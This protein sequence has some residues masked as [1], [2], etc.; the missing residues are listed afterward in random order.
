MASQ[1]VSDNIQ[2]N[3]QDVILLVDDNPDNLQVLYQTLSSLKFKILIAK[4]GQDAIEIAQQTHPALI[5]LDIMM[6]GVN[7]FEVIKQLKAN[8]V[9]ENSAVIF[10][11]A[12]DD[13]KHK[14]E[15]FKLGAV[16]YISKPFQG[17]EVLA[18]VRTHMKII[19]LERELSQKNEQLETD[20]SNIMQMMR[21]GLICLNQH[22]QICYANPAAIEL[23]GWEE[24]RLIKSNFHETIQFQ[25][26][27]KQRIPVQ[28]SHIIRALR[29]G[30]SYSSDREF[31]CHASGNIFAVEYSI[32]PLT[33]L[34]AHDQSANTK[35]AFIVF[36]DISLRKQN[37][38][39]LNKA[40]ETVSQ[41]KEKLEEE[42]QYLQ[43]EIKQGQSFCG[44]VGESTG[45]KNVLQEVEQ[46]AKTETTVLIY[47]ESGTGKEAIARA[48]HELSLRKERPLIK[49]NCAAIPESLV[50]SELFGHVKGAFTGAV[51]D[52]KGHFELA[53][54]G[55]I[56][57]DEIGE[58]SLDVQTKLLRV[59]QEQEIL[60][61][62][63]S[64]VKKVDVRFIAATH[65]DLKSMIDDNLFRLDLYY[66]LSVFPIHVPP[67]RERKG[68]IDLLAINFLQQLSKKLNKPLVSISED[69]LTLLNKYHWPGNIRELQNILERSAILSPGE[70][71]EIDCNMFNDSELSAQNN[72][73]ADEQQEIVSLA[74]NEKKY[75]IKILNRLDWVIG[76]KQGAAELLDLPVSTLRSRMKKLG[77]QK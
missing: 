4:S 29:E 37:E 59:L 33:D 65:R 76:G 30:E 55:T 13:L 39:Q 38:Q 70:V 77:I 34:S 17:P 5:L 57:L 67:L 35:G 31:F 51:S 36:K 46:V 75:I 23:L 22:A 63:S 49:V 12:L 9:T 27:N 3:S 40:L 41:L 68:D 42:N 53:D 44:I 60:P 56:F 24:Q 25:D 54:G 14:V 47:G 6:P 10:L 7:G 21:E 43:L 69:S 61:V 19:G 16:D 50:E 64:V 45:L 32:S 1:I 52:R 66:R 62:G 20:N 71:I 58:L 18:R 73:E 72:T 28:E 74:E 15:G 8:P 48:I 11:S 26:A 2:Y